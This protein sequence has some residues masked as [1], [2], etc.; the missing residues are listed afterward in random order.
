[1]ECARAYRQLMEE[2]KLTQEQ[3]AEKVGKSRT[4]IA[5]TVRLLKLP[6]KL[7]SALEAGEI[8][9]GH[10]RALLGLANP[11]QMLALAQQ[12]VSRGLSVRDVERMMQKAGEMAKAAKAAKPERKNSQGED[13]ALEEAIS[14]YFGSPARLER[15]PRGGRLSVEF[16]SED[17]LTRILDLLGVSL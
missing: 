8:S 4:A 5:N 1:M 13:P 14:I 12:I 10:A 6:E 15:G 11:A 16:Y 2:F 17:D 9:E 7:Q 3:V